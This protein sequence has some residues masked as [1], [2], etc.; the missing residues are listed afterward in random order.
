[1]AKKKTIL[2]IDD[3]TTTL[4]LLEWTLRQEGYVAKLALSVVEARKVIKKSTPDLIFLDLMMPN[5]SGFDFLK[6]RSELNIEHVP[7][8]VVSA[9]DSSESVQQAKELGAEEFIPKPY[10]IEHIVETVKKY[11]R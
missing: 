5:V 10:R 9:F 6:M 4:T 3:S 8:I 1:M 11:I 2:I 7:V